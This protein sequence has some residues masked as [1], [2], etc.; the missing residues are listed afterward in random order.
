VEE[1]IEWVAGEVKTVSDIVWQVNN[2]FDVL[3][4]KGVLSMLNNEGC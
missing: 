2:N 3:A 4:V 1:I